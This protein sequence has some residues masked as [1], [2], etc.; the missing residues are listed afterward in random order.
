[1]TFDQLVALLRAVGGGVGI[2]ALITAAIALYKLSRANTRAEATDRRVQAIEA[3]MNATINQSP[4]IA[5]NPTINLFPPSSG[6]DQ[7]ETK[8]LGEAQAAATPRLELTAEESPQ[9]SALPDSAAGLPH[10]GSE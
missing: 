9:P 3:T 8:T 10:P 7:P 2:A 4:T 1:M 6:K 5:F